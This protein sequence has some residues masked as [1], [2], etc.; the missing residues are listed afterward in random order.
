MGDAGPLR[1]DVIEFEVALAAARRASGSEAGPGLRQAVQLYRGEFL[2][3]VHV[4]EWADERRR[5][6]RVA[7]QDA[8]VAYGRTLDVADD[9]DRAVAILQRAV[10]HDPLDERA[11]RGFMLCVARAGEPAR[12]VRDY[13]ELAQR[14]RAEL[15]IAPA[16]RTTAVFRRIAHP[17]SA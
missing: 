1:C 16:D 15:G 17:S 13:Q 14:L 11:H 9:L 8:L 7:Y 12:A 10:E 4:G 5:A 2:A 3:G 6:L